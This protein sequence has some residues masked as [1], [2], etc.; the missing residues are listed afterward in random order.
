MYNSV[1]IN[2]LAKLWLNVEKVYKHS[3]LAKIVKS[4]GKAKDYLFQ[5]SKIKYF[6]TEDTEVIESSLSYKIFERFIKSINRIFTKINESLNK[7][8]SGSI[9]WRSKERAM[10][11]DETFYKSILAL[12]ITFLLSMV[13]VNL[14]RG[15]VK[16][17]FLLIPI[18]ILLFLFKNIKMFIIGMK[19]SA[20]Y[21][22]IKDLFVLD[23]EGGNQWW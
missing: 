17:L 2:F 1:L 18:I 6:I 21:C 3:L 22:F 14:L 8:T 20:I 9:I 4:L 11:E 13:I 16:Y 7:V 12:S 5:S 19:N 15:Y 23:E 10:K